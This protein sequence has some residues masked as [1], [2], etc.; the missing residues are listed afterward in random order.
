MDVPTVVRS[1]RLSLLPLFVS[2]Q[3]R[4]LILTT[5]V[6]RELPETSIAGESYGKVP[7]VLLAAAAEI[8]VT[9]EPLE[10]SVYRVR[11]EK[12]RFHG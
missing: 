8:G 12:P 3:G 9:P 4:C 10:G 1:D 7:R 6:V 5:R 11:Q 2:Q